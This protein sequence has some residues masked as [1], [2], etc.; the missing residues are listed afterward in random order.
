MNI[1]NITS[2]KNLIINRKIVNKPIQSCFLCGISW[3]IS[4]NISKTQG[5]FYILE[6]FALNWYNFV[7]LTNKSYCFHYNEDLN[8]IFCLNLKNPC[9]GHIPRI[10]KSLFLLSISTDE[11]ISNSKIITFHPCYNQVM[12]IL[13]A[14]RIQYHDHYKRVY[15]D[16]HF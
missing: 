3:K 9:V 12:K 1:D 5:C 7:A 13:N 10:S 2:I 15:L 6:S 14:N 4:W 11:L 16:Q 8:K